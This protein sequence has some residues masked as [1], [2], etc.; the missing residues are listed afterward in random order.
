MNYTKLIERLSKAGYDMHTDVYALL[1]EA[2]SAIE[3]L[4][5]ENERLKKLVCWN[6]EQREIDLA[7]GKAENDT[8]QSQLDAMSKGEPRFW[9]DEDMGELYSFSDNRPVDGLTPLYAA[10][11]ALASLTD[12][13]VTEIYIEVCADWVNRYN[14]PLIFARAIEAAHG[15]GGTP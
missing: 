11:K 15:L 9:Y 12:E 6:Q 1:P 5:A 2:V 8:L 3:A 4:Q 14:R 7:T 10:P 13:R